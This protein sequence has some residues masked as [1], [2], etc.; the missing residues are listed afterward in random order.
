[1]VG[2]AQPP[3]HDTQPLPQQEAV[4]LLTR[5]VNQGGFQKRQR[6]R[7]VME[8]YHDAAMAHY[9][10]SVLLNGVARATDTKCTVAPRLK[11]LPRILEKT[12]MRFEEPDNC[13]HVSDVVRAMVKAQSMKQVGSG[14][15]GGQHHPIR[16]TTHPCRPS[17][18][19]PHPSHAPRT[20]G[21][22]DP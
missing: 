13:E 1:M 2:G 18:A 17:N 22:D 20:A 8:L 11:G 14:N 4:E 16:P 5:V 10:F 15:G 21:A 12:M 6:T 9:P 7:D 19:L 3:P